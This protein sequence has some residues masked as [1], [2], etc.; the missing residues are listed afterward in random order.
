MFS[1]GVGTGPALPIPE[2]RAVVAVGLFVCYFRGLWTDK[3]ALFC[4]G[5][6]SS[7]TFAA[8][9][10]LKSNYAV[11]MCGRDALRRGPSRP[12]PAMTLGHLG[13]DPLE[14]VVETALRQ[15]AHGE[16]TERI[17]RTRIDL[18]EEHGRRTK[19]GSIV[20]GEP[21]NEKAASRLAEEMACMANTPGGGALIV[22]VADDGV[23]IG[24]ELDGDWLRYRIWQLT[25]RQLTVAVREERIDECRLLVLTVAEALEPVEHGGRLRWRVGSNCVEV[26]PVTWRAG[27]LQRVGYDWSA[28]PSGHAVA[29]VRPVALDTARRYLRETGGD[30]AVALAAASDIDLLARLHLLDADGRLTNAGSLLF[31]GTPYVG[32]DYMRRD[33]P[34]GDS[35]ER[36]EGTAPLVEQVREVEQA[37]RAANRV[38]HVRNGFVHAQIRAIPLSAFREAIVNG[39]THRDW[40]SPQPT[41]VEHIG[42]TLT[43]TSPGGFIGGVNPQNVITHPATPRY[44]SLAQALSTLGLAER[45]GIGID[46]MVREMLAIGRPPPV[47]SEV[48]GPYVRVTL[49]GGSPDAAV[50]SL[51]SAMPAAA[52]DVE[53]LL[54][55]ELLCRRGWV[56]AQSSAPTLQRRPEEADEAISRLCATSADGA[57]VAVAVRGVPTGLPQAC[58]LSDSVQQRLA[59]RMAL[60]RTTEG[61]DAMFLDWAGARGRV[62]STEAADLAGISV[63]YA[64]TRLKA[65]RAQGALEP[66]R[67]GRMGRGFFY[68]PAGR[69]GT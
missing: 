26:D 8:C 10:P 19:D 60:L 63:G 46:R 57:P 16:P 45:Q 53:S 62:S 44:R 34:G 17:E 36:V 48:S 32:I 65:L 23:L 3:V 13:P 58:R 67:P 59:G 68:V 5:A 54:L 33:V 15:L 35:T 61:R 40:A 21:T 14:Q 1:E 42:D 38:T 30:S 55:I 47:I 24:T 49:L 52:A 6:G 29:D 64:G 22:G 12:D 39:I 11:Q 18:K 25:R 2:S 20:P 37:G 51:V 31:V 27:M 7:V 43:V 9:E 69:T 66:G 50:V 56:D 41:T 28:Q 4:H